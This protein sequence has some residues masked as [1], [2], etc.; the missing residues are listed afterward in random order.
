MPVLGHRGKLWLRR[1][2]PEPVVLYV[3]SVNFGNNTLYLNNKGYW[4]GDEVSISCNL[5][6]PIDFGDGVGCP[7][8]HAV[9]FGSDWLLGSNRSH[10]TSDTDEFYTN[11]EAFF[12][13]RE[14]D[15]SLNDIASVFVY[16]DQLDRISFYI[17]QEAAL[18]GAPADRIPLSR[19][20]FGSLLLAPWGSSDYQNAL[21]LC[22]QSLDYSDY[23]NSDVRDEATLASLC[24]FAPSY[25]SPTAGVGDYNNADIRPR[26]SIN[27]TPDRSIWSIQG[28]LSDWSLNLTSQEID[29]T[30]LGE[31]YGESIKALITGG[32]TFDFL[33]SRRAINDANGLPR[34]DSTLL[35]RLLLMTEKG[36]NVDAQF[37]MIDSQPDACG[38]LPGD[39]F[40]ETRLM[41]T[42]IAINTRAA[43]IIAG[44]ANFVTIGSIDL[45][46]GTE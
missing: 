36:C 4:S 35:L 7:D 26:S 44:S 37:W 23:Q 6:L 17:N 14:E 5:G 22:T 18:R 10:I 33:V 24:Q 46:A 27:R 29:T 16:R 40:Y 12:Y 42:S 20:D 11:E 21:L 15:V 25:S 31:K 34:T 9:Y 1:E 38:L 39:L 32:G 45:R 28:D 43:E 2:A 41:I 8:G 13:L 3:N 30:A 19:V